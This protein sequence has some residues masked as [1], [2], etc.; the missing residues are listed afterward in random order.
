MATRRPKLIFDLKKAREGVWTIRLTLKDGKRHRQT[1][2]VGKLIRLRAG[3][4]LTDTAKFEFGQE[5]WGNEVVEA[6]WQW[7][8][9]L[10]DEQRRKALTN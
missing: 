10:I 9:G 8:M 2:D 7:Y 4:M 1:F 6:F 3:N 5:P